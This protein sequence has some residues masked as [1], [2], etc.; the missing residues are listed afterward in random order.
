MQPEKITTRIKDK[1]LELLE[2]FS[3]GLRYSE[4]HAKISAFDTHFNSN[5]INGSIWNLDAI[6]P[7]KVY[8]PR[9]Y[10][11]FSNI[12]RLTLIPVKSQ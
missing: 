10:F 5:T 12:N 9:V 6:F 8:K 3:K 1:A 7:D 2:Q 4:L 11:A